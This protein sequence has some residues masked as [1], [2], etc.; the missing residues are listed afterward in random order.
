MTYKQQATEWHWRWGEER[1]KVIALAD[2]VDNLSMAVKQL[3]HA[4]KRHEP[5]SDTAARA[6]Q[7]LQK[8]NLIGSPLR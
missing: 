2:H 4:L 3:C 5:D 1:A 7:Y 8:H 6:M